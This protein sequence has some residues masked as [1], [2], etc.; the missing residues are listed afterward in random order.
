MEERAPDEGDAQNHAEKTT[1]SKASILRFVPRCLRVKKDPV[2]IKDARVDAAR[3]KFAQAFPIVKPKET[4]DDISSPSNSHPM[5][6]P[7]TRP[8]SSLQ[9][10]TSE[11]NTKALLAQKA[12]ANADE[13]RGKAE[14]ARQQADFMKL[15]KEGFGFTDEQIARAIGFDPN[16]PTCDICKRS[17]IPGPCGEPHE[18]TVQHKQAVEA[19]GKGKLRAEMV[20]FAAGLAAEFPASVPIQSS[21]PSVPLSF[22]ARMLAKQG[23]DSSQNLGL[24][25]KGQ[26]ITAPIELQQKNDKFGIGI[27]PAV[28]K[29][30][31]IT[32]NGAAPQGV[33]KKKTF[34]AKEMRKVKE[35][36]RQ[37][38]QHLQ[39]LFMSSHDDGTAYFKELSKFKKWKTEV[40]LP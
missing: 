4:L 23:Y 2:A 13:A 9:F 21:S 40:G 34:D 36:E 18:D 37:W 11:D 33:T 27:K 29:P 7:P 5:L 1:A 31:Q 19:Q 3:T 25:A 39:S 32:P 14:K 12:Q 16:A 26:G 10:V 30:V 8:K 35:K 22:G 6:D 20:E 38:S 24:G 28:K 15:Y 17:I